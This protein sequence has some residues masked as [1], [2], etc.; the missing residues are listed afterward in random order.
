MFFAHS[1]AIN[2]PEQWQIRIAGSRGSVEVFPFGSESKLRLSHGGYSDLRDV[3]PDE[4]PEGSIDI[5]YEI[6]QF[7]QAIREAQPSPIP[8]DTFLYT[9]MIFDGLYQSSRLGREVPVSL[10]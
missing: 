5:T 2:F 10:P 7:V 4:L 6:K 3:T 1:W 9:N 8:G